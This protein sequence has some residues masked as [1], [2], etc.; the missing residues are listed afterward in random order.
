[1]KYGRYTWGEL[2]AICNKL[3]GES[4]MDGILKDTIRIT[5]ETIYPP[6][7]NFTVLVDETQSVEEAVKEGK[8]D[9]YNGAENFISENF[10]KLINGQRA[11]KKVSL[12][13]F[14]KEISSESV[15][16]EMNK[17]GYKPATI[18][19][20]IGLAAEMPD[21]QKQF[22]IIAL[23]SFYESCHTGRL[24]PCIRS[25]RSNLDPKFGQRELTLECFHGNW[26]NWQR[27]AG[28]KK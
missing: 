24:A 3:G 15:I 23:G 9:E 18:W 6:T 11:N 26:Y 20:L 10:P 28:V 25:I 7:H 14:G 4:V 2:E 13:Y 16:S 8:F 17:V 5:T 12:F 21:L 22:S 1:M 19:D 27:F